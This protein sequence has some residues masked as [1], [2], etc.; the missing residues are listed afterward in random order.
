VASS[1]DPTHDGLATWAGRLII[2]FA[3]GF[4]AVLTFHQPALALLHHAG[5]TPIAAYP[6]GPTAPFGIPR[7][8]SLAL[9]GGVWALPLAL[10][11]TWVPRPAFWPAAALFGA[12]GPSLVNWLVVLP[13]KGAPMGGGWHPAGIVTALVINGAWGLGTA[14]IWRGT[15]ALAFRKARMTAPGA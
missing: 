5:I 10:V 11:L 4:F 15:M 6:M 14:F 8:F 3:A 12:L 7:V 9:W 1:V 13:L 2:A